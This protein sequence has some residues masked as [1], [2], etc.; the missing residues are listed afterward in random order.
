MFDNEY[1]QFEVNDHA[2]LKYYWNKYPIKMFI[3]I[4][5]HGNSENNVPRVLNNTSTQYL[6]RQDHRN[7]HDTNTTM[8]KDVIRYNNERTGKIYWNSV[9]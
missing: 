3:N 5:C 1:Q 2:M 7:V 8:P 4:K 9:V 6:I